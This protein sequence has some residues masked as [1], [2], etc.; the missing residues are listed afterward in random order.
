MAKIS[1]RGEISL[2]K[3][4]AFTTGTYDYDD[5]THLPYRYDYIFCLR[6]DGKILRRNAGRTGSYK[7][8]GKVKSD[9]PYTEESLRRIV[10][11]LGYRITK[12]SDG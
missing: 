7:I 8:I 1:A 4:W 6:S 11:K 2:A 12:S 10:G 5:G 9:V 3:V